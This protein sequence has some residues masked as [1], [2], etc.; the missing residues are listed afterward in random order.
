MNIEN[1]VNELLHAEKH[2]MPIE[3]LTASP[4]GI[5]VDGAYQ[6]QLGIVDYRL[7]NG[8]A[9][10]GKKIG[11]TSKAMQKMLGVNEPDYGHL[12]DD[13]L[14]QENTP[15]SLQPYIQPRIE[16]EIAFVLKDDL[17]GPDVTVEKVIEATDYVVPAMEIIDSRIKDWKIQFAD[18]I[19]DNGS[20]AGVILGSQ[21]TKIYEINP[22]KV[23]MTVFQNG[24]MVD[25][26]TGAA[27]MGNPVQAV[28]W[29]ANTLANYGIALKAGEVI[30]AGSLTKAIDIADGDTFEAAFSIGSVKASFHI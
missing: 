5:T 7:K 1:A 22:E 20:S 12:F 19:A 18:T 14:F 2:K 21:R 30:L 10:I 15:V 24:Q 29:L 13:M 11:L 16:F 8:A 28:A 26:A 4:E 9:I 27:V 6:I 17:K 23:E 3:P 25:K